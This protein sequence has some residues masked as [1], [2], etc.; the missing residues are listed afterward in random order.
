M[1][2]RTLTDTVGV[3][4]I[5]IHT[6]ADSLVYLSPA[7][8]GAGVVFVSGGVQIPAHVDSVVDTSRCTVLGKD[9]VTVSTVEHL[10]SCF[11][12]LG[13]T[14]AIVEVTGPELPIGDGGSGIW[15]ETAW[16]GAGF[17]D[18]ETEIMVPSL[19]GPLMVSGK[20]GSF[21]AAYPSNRL[22]LTVAAVFDHPLVGTQV[23]RFDARTENYWDS[24][25]DEIAQARTFGFIEEVEALRKAGLALGGSEENAV[26][27]YPD[28][29]SKPL[30]FENE[31]A[32]HK[33]LDMMGD[34][35]L[36]ALPIPNMEI[37]AVKPSHRLNVEFARLLTASCSADM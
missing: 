16:N 29:Y 24:Y 1:T 11:A 27:I 2:R 14:D 23:A 25:T 26:V 10:L 30:R 9:G 21:I 4:G 28:R 20:N 6:G 3:Q 8:F 19:A 32:R 31:L 37:F 12:G 34:L 7:P 36:A 33:L 22:L 13:V 35:A 18:S 15:I 17:T 5:G